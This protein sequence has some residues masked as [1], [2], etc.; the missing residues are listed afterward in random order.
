MPAWI[1][2]HDQ[3]WKAKRKAISWQSGSGWCVTLWNV[4]PVRALGEAPLEWLTELPHT[5]GCSWGP[6]RAAL[7]DVIAVRVVLTSSQI[8]VFSFSSANVGSCHF[9]LQLSF[10]WY[11]LTSLSSESLSHW[12]FSLCLCGP[13]CWAPGNLGKKRAGCA[14]S[15]VDPHSSCCWRRGRQPVSFDALFLLPSWGSVF[16]FCF[17][18]TF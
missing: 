10:L 17:S 15:C 18:K 6:D 1:I 9:L 8:M 13:W 3:G 14:G 12:L 11:Q 4:C 16:H 7:L 5:H 2:P